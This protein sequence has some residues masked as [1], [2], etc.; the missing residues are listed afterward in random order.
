MSRDRPPPA[1]STERKLPS[2]SLGFLGLAYSVL[3][4]SIADFGHSHWLWWLLAIVLGL[5]GS[6]LLS[7]PLSYWRSPLLRWFQSEFLSFISVFVGAFMVAVLLAWVHFLLVGLL[8]FSA[9]ALA[10]LDLLTGRFT[11]LQSGL[12]LAATAQAG[13]GFGWMLHHL[14]LI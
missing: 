13:L 12:I 4:W 10:R 9:M 6:V 2:A 14:M 11:C 8:L 1:A 7:L 3:G 5:A